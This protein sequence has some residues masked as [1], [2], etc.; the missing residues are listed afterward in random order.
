MDSW[1][2]CNECYNLLIRCFKTKMCKK[3]GCSFFDTCIYGSNLWIQLFVRV[4]YYLRY[5]LPDKLLETHLHYKE[6]NIRKLPFSTFNWNWVFNWNCT[7]CWKSNFDR[8][9]FL[10]LVILGL[11]ETFQ[12]LFQND[13][14]KPEKLSLT[15]KVVIFLGLVVLVHLG[16]TLACQIYILQTEG[17]NRKQIHK[18]V[19]SVSKK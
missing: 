3:D 12:I 10:P 5:K 13:Q 9:Q 18:V 6:T 16:W 17:L 15:G 7:Q 4:I 19:S 14:K 11:N 8:L 2:H 1:Q